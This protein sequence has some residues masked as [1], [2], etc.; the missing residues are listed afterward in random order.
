M[1]STYIAIDEELLRRLYVDERLTAEVIARQFGCSP[2]TVFRRLRRFGIQARSRGPTRGSRRHSPSVPPAW[3]PKI[4]WVVGVIATDGCLGRNGRQLTVSS[5]D[6]D[7]LETVRECLGGRGS[8]TPYRKGVENSCFHLQWGDRE[9]HAWLRR[10]GLTPAKSLTL[11]PLAVPDEYFADFFRGCVDGD[12]TV[13]VY[14]DRYHAAKNE[15]YV[16]ERLYVS[17]VS[18]SRAFIDWIR[19][20]ITRLCGVTGSVSVRTSQGH[21]PVWCLKYAKCESIVLLRWIYYAPD[22][23]SLARKRARAD[24]FL[25]PL[26]Y[27]SARPTGRPRVG[28]LY[29]VTPDGVD[30]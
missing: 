7:F 15:H 18:A 19:Q 1:Q 20:T 13:L 10:L 12:G 14:T 30:V 2:I 11:G 16:Y 3:S 6:F 23:P 5:K 17:L 9:L 8:I 28:W 21:H 29:N 26:G 27:A 4:A 24:K 22:I 25:A